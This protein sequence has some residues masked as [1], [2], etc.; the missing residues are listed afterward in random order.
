MNMTFK[1]P[2]PKKTNLKMTFANFFYRGKQICDNSFLFQDVNYNNEDVQIIHSLPPYNSSNP[3]DGLI[4]CNSVNAFM[5]EMEEENVPHSAENI[6]FQMQGERLEDL[7]HD[8]NSSDADE[9][10][11]AGDDND[12]NN[13][14]N[15]D[16]AIE[17]QIFFALQ[18]Y[19]NEEN[20]TESINQIKL[21][22]P[23]YQSS[24][25]TD[26]V[27]ACNSVNELILEMEEENLSN[28]AKNITKILHGQR[29][30]ELVHDHNNSDADEKNDGVQEES[31]DGN[32]DAIVDLT[33]Q[34]QNYFALG[35]Y[36]NKYNDTAS[37]DQV[38]HSS[39]LYNSSNLEDGAIVCCSVNEFTMEIEKENAPHSTENLDF[40]TAGERMEELDADENNEAHE[41]ESNLENDHENIDLL[42]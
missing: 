23:S 4:V 25:L 38:D 36:D 27:L 33:I 29:L 30:D 39:L 11:D 14:I 17:G 22:L 12:G 35:K 26:C 19:S 28:F 20:D 21:S 13:Q 24:N 7:V 3:A 40:Q 16:F 34:G 1:N 42:V 10:N 37:I 8:Y 31:N 6:D 2:R 32:D 5:L 9:S 41:E 15:I 18:N